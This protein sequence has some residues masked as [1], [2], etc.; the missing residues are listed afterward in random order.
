M[1]TEFTYLAWTAILTLAIR[2]PWMINKVTVRGLDKVTHYPTESQLLSAWAR[3][4]WLAHEDALQGLLV[5]AV[6]VLTL[7]AT[8]ASNIWTETA[9]VVYFWARLAHFLVY[10]FGVPHLKTLAFLATFAAQVVL[11]WQLVLAM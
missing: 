9:A 8:D 11:A 5:F 6:L 10:A 3:R 2:V 4:A 1:T 7:H